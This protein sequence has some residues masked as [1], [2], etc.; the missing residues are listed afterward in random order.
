MK[1]LLISAAMGWLLVFQATAAWSAPTIYSTDIVNG[2]VKNVDLSANAVTTDKILDGAV[3][4]ADLAAASVSADKLAMAVYTK[5][6]VDTLIAGL[7]AQ[8]TDLLSRV[9]QLES[10]PALALGGYVAV[11]ASEVNG[12]PGPN[13]VISGANLHV[14]SG[15]GSTEGLINGLGNVIIG[16]NELRSWSSNRRDGSHNLVLGLENNYWGWSGMVSGAANSIGH[17]NTAIS[18]QNSNVSGFM[19]AILGGYENTI[20]GTYSTITG[21]R[22]NNASAF[23]ASVSGGEHNTAAGNMSSVSGGSWSSVSGEWDWMAGDLFQEQ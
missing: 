16:Y 23:G 11:T 4:N 9:S 8:I 17:Y 2:E 13:V 18:T 5:A 15:S 6:E 19:S 14:L 12:A 7:Q 22:F 3:S 20:T 1:K 10:N 21:G